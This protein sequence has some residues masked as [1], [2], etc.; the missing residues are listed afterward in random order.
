M[1]HCLRKISTN[2][3]RSTHNLNYFP[4]EPTIRL[5][6]QS[7]SANFAN[8]SLSVRRERVELSRTIRSTVLQ[9]A[10]G[11]Y[12]TTAALSE[13]KKKSFFVL[14]IKWIDYVKKSYYIFPF[15]V[16]EFL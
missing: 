14:N 9:T 10:P 1:S 2:S 16:A 5:S 12:G 3:V 6:E 13:N 11:P 7:K 4:L 15:L 8:F